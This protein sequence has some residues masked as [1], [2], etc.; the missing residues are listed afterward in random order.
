[1]Q[2]D[3]STKSSEEDL[4]CNGESRATMTGIRK[5]TRNHL[6][7]FFFFFFFFLRSK[8]S[9]PQ[10]VAFAVSVNRDGRR[11]ACRE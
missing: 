4:R 8:K 6:F 7:A 3:C 5:G 10:F 9:K 11:S 1:M 2:Q